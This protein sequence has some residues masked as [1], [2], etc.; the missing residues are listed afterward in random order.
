ME[1][2]LRVGYGHELIDELRRAV[3]LH[4]W[5]MA[6]KGKARG[7]K[8]MAKVS[9]SLKAAARKRND[10]I[11][12]YIHNWSRISK[13]KDAGVLRA[14]GFNSALQ[15]LQKLDRQTDIKF[16]EE[17]GNRTGNYVPASGNGASWI[18]QVAM[19]GQIRQ[20]NEDA[21]LS[22]IERMT[23]SWESEGILCF[24]LLLLVSIFHDSPSLGLGARLC[25][26]RA[27]ERRGP[28]CARRDTASR[29][30]VQ[31]SPRISTA[32]RAREKEISRD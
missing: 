28:P 29:C 7:V 21:P 30:L 6:G 9:G 23:K 17:W 19:S 2:R 1:L 13:L 31:V 14:D 11:S 10:I 20:V 24:L 4:S 22:D 12:D 5:L 8:S 18:W 3:G 26:D 16:F 32:S 25:K 15:G 27:L